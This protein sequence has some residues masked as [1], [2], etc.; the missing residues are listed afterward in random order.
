MAERPK[1]K[2][3]GFLDLLTFIVLEEPHDTVVLRVLIHA[4]ENL[5]I[6]FRKG[7]QYENCQF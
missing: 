4:K 2:K 1:V 3:V 5:T 7:N 6:S